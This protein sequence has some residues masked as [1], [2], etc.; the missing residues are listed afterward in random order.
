[1][2]IVL[3]Y[4]F[5]DYGVVEPTNNAL[6]S[7]L[8]WRRISFGSQSEAGSQFVARILTVVTALK[9]QRRNPVDYLAQAFQAKRLGLATPSLVPQTQVDAETLVAT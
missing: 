5:S 6:R 3:V 9:A 7:G 4:D 8:I 2:D 1:M